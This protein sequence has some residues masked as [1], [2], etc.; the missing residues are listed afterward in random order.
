MKRREVERAMRRH[1]CVEANNSGRGSHEKWHCPCG[2]HSANIPRHRDI[3]PGVIGDIVRR[4]TC[5][6][7]G[8]LQ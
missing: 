6:P 3:S 4:L 2:K 5:L 8:W 7:E 1:G